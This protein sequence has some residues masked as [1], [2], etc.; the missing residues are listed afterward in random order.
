M[1]D[2]SLNIINIYAP[3]SDTEHQNFYS[4]ITTYLSPTQ[5]NILGGDL[6]SI[7]DPKLDKLGGDPDPRQSA[8]NNLNRI[9]TQY[10]LIDIWRVRNPH[11]AA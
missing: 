11:F 5:A 6:N 2:H 7:S 10:D 9:T 4:T 3:S 8:V 1:D